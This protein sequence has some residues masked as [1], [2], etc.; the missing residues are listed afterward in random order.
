MCY[1]KNEEKQ[2]VINTYHITNAIINQ[3]NCYHLKNSITNDVELLLYLGYSLYRTLTII[4]N[5]IKHKE[6]RWIK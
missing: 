6:K 2:L 3:Y 5:S 4:C 1:I